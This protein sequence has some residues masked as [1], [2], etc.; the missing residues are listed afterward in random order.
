MTERTKPAGLTIR[1]EIS[2]VKNARGRYSGGRIYLWIRDGIVAG[3]MGC[4]PSRYMGRTIA[5]ARHIAR[6]GGIRGSK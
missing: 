2:K 4:E 6:Y 5:A 1:P 3:A